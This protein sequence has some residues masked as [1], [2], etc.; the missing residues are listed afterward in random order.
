M[1]QL[2]QHS[3]MRSPLRAPVRQTARHAGPRNASRGIQHR[4][5]SRLTLFATV[6]SPPSFPHKGVFV[7]ALILA[8]A[9]GCSPA[10]AAGSPSSRAE[11][12]LRVGPVRRAH[13]VQ[14]PA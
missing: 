12:S 9:Q 2:S 14:T 4:L 7:F 13:A 6:A 3:K 1:S 8:R 5:I 10:Y 11:E